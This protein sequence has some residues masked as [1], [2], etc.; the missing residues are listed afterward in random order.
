MQPTRDAG[1]VFTNVP[2]NSNG[3][4]SPAGVGGLLGKG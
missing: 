2:T 4:K 3:E 1:I